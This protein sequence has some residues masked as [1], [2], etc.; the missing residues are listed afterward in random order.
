MGPIT[1]R[2]GNHV[3]FSRGI[4]DVWPPP[5][6]QTAPE[7]SNIKIEKVSDKVSETEATKT[8]PAKQDTDFD[9][10][11]QVIQ[12]EENDKRPGVLQK[13]KNNK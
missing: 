8:E 13:L 1:I 2:F 10:Y 11:G 4:V 12:K 5:V 9:V 3:L 7:T 6:E